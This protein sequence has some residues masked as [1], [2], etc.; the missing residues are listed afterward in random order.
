MTHPLDQ[1]LSFCINGDPD[2]SEK[3]LRQLLKESPDDLR[4]IFNL[5]WHDM[6]HGQLKKGFES[7]NFGRYINVFGS[8]PLPGPIW[9]D[10]DLNGKVLLLR[11]EGGFGDEI[12]NFR[13]AKDFQKLGAT[14]VVACHPA[15]CSIFAK[16][17][18]PTV[19]NKAAEQTGVY[20][21]YWVPAMSAAYVLGYEF[22]TLPGAPYIQS[23]VANVDKK[24]G[25]I[26]V[27]VKWS[28]NPKFE[29]EQ[30]RKFPTQLMLDLHK[31]PG[32]TMYSFQRDED[33]V[34]DL[35]FTDL[36]PKLK[37]W[38]DTAAYLKSMDLVITSCTSIAHMAAALGVET[39]VV[40]PVMPY[41]TWAVPGP[42][43]A[44]HETVTLFRQEKYNQWESVF[45]KVKLELEK[46][47]ALRAVA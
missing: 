30:H 8:G 18:F 12:I 14:V 34:P 27:G 17:G 47:T 21:D 41:Y 16:Q 36:G 31:V 23:P 32:V 44:W 24:P 22:D 39:W 28:G 26:K 7:I 6:R 3:I 19:T 10:E 46:K 29:H 15:L 20:Y 42:K 5:G 33:L 37:T 43:S 38:D 1:A 35:P 2:T 40:I 9:K 4:A 11:S 13:F 45:E 25:T